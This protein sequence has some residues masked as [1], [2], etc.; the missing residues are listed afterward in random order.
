MSFLRAFEEKYIEA[1]EARLEAEDR[2]AAAHMEFIR[3]ARDERRAYQAHADLQAQDMFNNAT[4][5]EEA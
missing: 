2:L 5:K 3:A 1:M 4:L